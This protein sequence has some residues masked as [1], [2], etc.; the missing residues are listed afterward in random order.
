M[1]YVG[2]ESG[3]DRVLEMVDKDVTVRGLIDANR[4]LAGAGIRPHYS[5]MAGLPGEKVQD[6]HATIGLMRR[7]RSDHPGAIL[8][9]IKGY[10]PYPGTRVFQRAVDD[11]FGPP[12]T[13][14]EWSRLNWNG[15]HRP[16]LSRKQARLVEKA[17]YVTFGLD[18]QLAE[19]FGVADHRLVAWFLRRYSSICR[20]RCDKDNLGFVPELPVLRAA[21]RVLGSAWW[22]PKSRRR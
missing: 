6:I 12:R 20:R 9:P 18:D 14:E 13:L 3:S 5:F 21:K 2:A 4:R 8:S 15:A 22:P 17:T 1:L 10:I 19:N 16:W 7:L 11:G